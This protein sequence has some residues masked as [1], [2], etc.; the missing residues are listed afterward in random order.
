MTNIFIDISIILEHRSKVVKG[1]FVWYHLTIKS[2][3]PYSCV[4]AH[5]LHFMYSILDLLNLKYFASK[6]HLHNFNF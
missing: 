4:V 1:V 3:I 2:N 5:K 6:V